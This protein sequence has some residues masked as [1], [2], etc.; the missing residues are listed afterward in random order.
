MQ[1]NSQLFSHK[2]KP[3]LPSKLLYD[4]A[5]RFDECL[6][7]RKKKESCNNNLKSFQHLSIC[8][9][10]F[11]YFPQESFAVKLCPSI[12]NYSG[13][14]EGQNILWATLVINCLIQLL[15][16]LSNWQKLGGGACAQSPP[17]FRHPCFST[18]FLP[19]LMNQIC[20]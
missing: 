4:M 1:V 10:G 5:W 6:N 2:L 8:M 14:A 11:K 19:Y 17:P 15:F 18:L 13:T 9:Y 20:T 7:S 3:N 16:L 12:T